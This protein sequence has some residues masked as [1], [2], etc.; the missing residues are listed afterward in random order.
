MLLHEAFKVVNITY[1]RVV[2]VQL[3][4]YS[5]LSYLAQ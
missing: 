4:F 1:S 3:A 2:L 5:V